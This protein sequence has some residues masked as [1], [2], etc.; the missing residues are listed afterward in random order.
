VSRPCTQNC[1]LSVSGNAYDCWLI[2]I[3][4]NCVKISARALLEGHWKHEFYIK[5]RTNF[6]GDIVRRIDGIRRVP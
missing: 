3:F 2:I 1:I 5:I 4:V 6:L